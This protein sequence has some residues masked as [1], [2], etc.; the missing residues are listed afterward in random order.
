[1]DLSGAP[2]KKFAAMRE[3]HEAEAARRQVKIVRDSARNFFLRWHA[4]N[5]CAS[6]D[7][8]YVARDEIFRSRKFRNRERRSDRTASTAVRFG[9]RR[10]H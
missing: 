1:M 5:S 4:K 3:V 9:G 8:G 10:R 2:R 7:V 6:G